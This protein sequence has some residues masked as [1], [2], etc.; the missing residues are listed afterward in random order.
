MK[1][2]HASQFI[3]ARNPRNRKIPTAKFPARALGEREV[4]RLLRPPRVD[5]IGR[6][7]APALDRRWRGNL[8][9]NDRKGF[10]LKDRA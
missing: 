3:E 10:G 1:N 2:G 4:I 5:L 7:I 9:G 6:F 8:A